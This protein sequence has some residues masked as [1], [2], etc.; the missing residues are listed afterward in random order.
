VIKQATAQ[1]LE[2][3]ISTFEQSLVDFDQSAD[4]ILQGGTLG[5]GLEV[6]PTDNP[7]LATK[8]KQ[9]DQIHNQQFQPAAK[10][11]IDAGK[12][13][14][15]SYGQR[16]Q[17]K[18]KMEQAFELVMLQAD[19]AETVI[20]Q[21]ADRSDAGHF[22]GLVDAT[23]ELKV[24]IQQ[25]LLSLN[26]IMTLNQQAKLPSLLQGY[27][28]TLDDFDNIVQGLLNG[29]VVDGES[30][31]E[32]T[33]D[34][35][36]AHVK[37][38]DL[39]HEQFQQ[40]AGQLIEVQQQLLKNSIIVEDAMMRLD[41][42]GELAAQSLTQVEEMSMAEMQ[43]ALDSANNNSETAFLTLAI[44]A[45][46]SVGCGILLGWKTSRSI[47]DPL[48]GE[49]L[50]M[51][52]IARAIADGNLSNQ[53]AAN[54]KAQGAY[55]AMLDMSDKLRHLIGEISTS[56]DMLST[57]AQETAS[58]SEQTKSGVN[59]QH[60]ETEQVATAMNQMVSTVQ[61]VARN[62][63]ET[64]R[65]TGL[66]ND[67]TDK[68]YA[69]VQQTISAINEVATK[70]E[71]TATV[72]QNLEKSS[73]DIASVLDVIR[74]IADQT[75]LL[76]LNAAIEAARAGEQGRGFSVVADEVRTLAQRTQSSTA[77]IQAMIETLQ[78]NAHT[79]VSEMQQSVKQAH[80]SVA[81]AGKAGDALTAIQQAIGHINDMNTQVASAA[82]EQSVVAEQINQSISSISSI[83]EQT[84]GGAESTASASVE[85]A[86][87]ADELR[88][89]ISV[90]S[91]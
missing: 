45:V 76:A 9:A 55:K 82:E 39:A 91:V 28:R 35:A 34:I 3:S 85:I 60:Q 53:F 49:P 67:E 36:I 10:A 21:Q 31:S 81:Q 24:L 14:V 87:M 15:A 40:A 6:Y 75:N 71:N 29:G 86:G 73:D 19:E 1:D 46:F 32:L 13:L 61:E 57:A 20:Q 52:K 26:A 42:S 89:K 27:Q 33:N 11:M 78:S 84:A 37:N 59:S 4:A 47:T 44:T 8:V 66:A 30:I 51:E 23:M 56:S 83:G 69:T 38:L 25:S 79:A 62:A 12:Q 54:G 77:D 5:S 63:S 22:A 70:I 64:A 48:G 16:S 72:I 88:Q 43:A 80:E 18:V 90:F 2:S 7:L 65:A 41:Q 58:I 74:G 68:G 17:A 50:Q